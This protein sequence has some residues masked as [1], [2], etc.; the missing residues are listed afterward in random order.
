MVSIRHLSSPLCRRLL[1]LAFLPPLAVGSLPAPSPLRAQPITS[2]TPT[3]VRTVPPRA[4]P[5]PALEA[6]LREVL[7]PVRVDDGQGHG[8]DP[9][10]A[11]AE[12]AKRAK[13]K[14]ECERQ[15]PHRYI[16]DRIDLNDDGRDEVVA[17]VV[18]PTV[19]GT[20]GCTL[21][22][23]REPSPGRLPLITRM[24]LFQDPLIVSERH[25]NGWKELITRVRV[26][27]GTSYYARLPFEDGRY[28]ENPSVPPA[29]PLNRPEPGTALLPWNAEDLRAHV[30]PCGAASR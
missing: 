17:R 30:L 21:L 24:T 20:G 13:I 26:D 15:P 19:C 4:K 28:P 5:D 2:A 3:V 11:E 8:P 22:I 12:M 23:F 27:A 16:W 29:S 25:S 6:A 7:F 18:G 1:P 10:S 14:A 9:G